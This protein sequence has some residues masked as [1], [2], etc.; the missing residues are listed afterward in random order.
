MSLLMRLWTRKAIDYIPMELKV[1]LE[2]ESNVVAQMFTLNQLY[3]GDAPH[4]SPQNGRHFDT[5]VN[6]AKHEKI[7]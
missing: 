2:D 6:V 3:S 5:L 7:C 1:I 4:S